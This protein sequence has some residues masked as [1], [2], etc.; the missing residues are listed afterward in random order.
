MDRD[1]HNVWKSPV[2]N[3]VLEKMF[4]VVIGVERK[5]ILFTPLSYGKATGF[6]ISKS[7]G[8]FLK[9]NLMKFLFCIHE[10]ILLDKMNTNQVNC[11][12]S[13]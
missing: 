13:C 11:A 1:W 6:L 2:N 9:M 4:P 3:F 12:K 8:S 7:D 5:I 10:I